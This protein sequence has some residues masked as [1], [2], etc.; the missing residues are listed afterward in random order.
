MRRARL[1]AIFLP[2]S[3]CTPEVTGPEA[4]N[5][6]TPD[7]IDDNS[8][9]ALL[10]GEA[11]AG[12]TGGYQLL[13]TGLQVQGFAAPTGMTIRLVNSAVQIPPTIEGDEPDFDEGDPIEDVIDDAETPVEFQLG[14]NSRH[15]ADVSLN[16]GAEPARNTGEGSDSGG[17]LK[18]TGIE[19]QDDGALRLTGCFF[20]AADT[21]DRD[22]LVTVTEGAFSIDPQ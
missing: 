16:T 1:F 19:E 5:C 14:D 20:Y 22:A 9:V 7:D 10:D 12:T 4:W 2:L 18:L 17:Y 15:G 3:A 13:S 11:W 21:S 8:V 6:E